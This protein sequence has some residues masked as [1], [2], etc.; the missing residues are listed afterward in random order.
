MRKKNVPQPHQVSSALGA[1]GFLV[2]PA[3]IPSVITTGK[4]VFL[5]SVISFDGQNLL[6]CAVSGGFVGKSKNNMRYI[7]K[8]VR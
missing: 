2:V 3:R 1:G 5:V 8:L 6:F 4:F 7:A